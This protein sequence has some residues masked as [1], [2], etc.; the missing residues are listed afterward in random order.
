MLNCP[1]EPHYSTSILE[2]LPGKLDIKRHLPSI[3]YL[4]DGLIRVHIDECTVHF[5]HFDMHQLNELQR[6][7]TCLQ[8]FADNKGPDQPV[9]LRSLISTFIIHYL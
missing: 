9:H 8:G 2:A 5:V 6:E 3:L 7:T 4:S 1:A